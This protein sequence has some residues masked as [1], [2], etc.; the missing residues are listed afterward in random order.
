M[1]G[2]TARQRISRKVGRLLS[3]PWPKYAW[4]GGYPYQYIADDG[5]SICGE[6][7]NTQTE[8]HFG[9]VNDG[10]KILD[11]DTCEDDELVICAHCNT[12]IY[13]PEG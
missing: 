10:W 4:P 12:T 5:E 8:I 13:N 11:A 3:Q 1:E 7:M 2:I 9:G 6:C